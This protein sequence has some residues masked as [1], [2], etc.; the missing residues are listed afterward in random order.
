MKYKTEPVEREIRTV[1]AMI[2][3]YCSSVHGQEEL[4]A[5]CSEL[6]KYAETRVEKCRFGAEKPA[7]K[8]CPVHCYSRPMREK[9]REVMRF[10]GP[11]M[12]WKHPVMAFLHLLKHKQKQTF[13]AT[14]QKIF[15][16]Q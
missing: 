6:M 14:P 5:E 16:K 3:I 2:R 10:S 4:C 1:N 15:I 9:I 11:R 13:A 7:C 12:M 8:D